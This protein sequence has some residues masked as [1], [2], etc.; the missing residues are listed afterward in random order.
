M[1]TKLL[2]VFIQEYEILIYLK[3]YNVMGLI[4]G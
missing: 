3:L 2:V 4:E 1:S